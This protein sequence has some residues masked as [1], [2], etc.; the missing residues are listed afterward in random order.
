MTISAEMTEWRPIDNE[1]DYAER[2]LV[3]MSIATDPLD[4]GTLLEFVE[5][6][7]AEGNPMEDEL[8]DPLVV[9]N[10]LVRDASALEFAFE[11]RATEEERCFSVRAYSH[12]GTL[13]DQYAGPCLQWG[14]GD[15]EDGSEKGCASTGVPSSLRAG[16][17]AG[18]LV[19][20]MRRRRR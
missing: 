6:P 12:D 9:A 3:S 2:I 5:E 7:S 20:G 1:C 8:P 16:W 13:V 10:H 18:L 14:A 15:G 19:L 4:P 17:L 11:I